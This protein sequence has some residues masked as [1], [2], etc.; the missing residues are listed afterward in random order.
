MK[1]IA[2]KISGGKNQRK[3][4]LYCRVLQ[5]SRQDFYDYL[6]RRNRPWKYGPL[7]EEMRQILSEDKENDTYGRK[8]MYEALRLRNPEGAQAASPSRASARSTGL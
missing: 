6:Q 8:R 5:V 3:L 2:Q 1:F 4:S 7:A